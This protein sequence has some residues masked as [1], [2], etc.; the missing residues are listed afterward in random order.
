MVAQLLPSF[1]TQQN[2][3]EMYMYFNSNLDT[4]AMLKDGSQFN[5]L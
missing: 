2:W 4:I 3:S 1:K 5:P